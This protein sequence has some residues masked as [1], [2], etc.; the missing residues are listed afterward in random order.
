MLVELSDELLSILAK[1][2]SLIETVPDSS[3]PALSSAATSGFP[4]ASSTSTSTSTDETKL[5]EPM[6]NRAKTKTFCG[7]I[8][9]VSFQTICFDFAEEEVLD[10][11][12]FTTSDQSE[13][14]I[15]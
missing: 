6:S 12:R 1:S 4:V 11:D 2:K 8:F 9:F 15:K 3:S 14:T 7:N 5:V 10:C 13:E